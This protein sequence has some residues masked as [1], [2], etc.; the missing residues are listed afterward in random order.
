MAADADRAS[1]RSDR[2]RRYRQEDAASDD[3]AASE[4]VDAVARPSSESA[5]ELADAESQ[6]GN[7]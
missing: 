7:T 4:S 2:L 5:E 1:E 3:E 6:I